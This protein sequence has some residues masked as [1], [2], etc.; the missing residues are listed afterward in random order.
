MFRHLLSFIA[1]VD[2]AHA[3]FNAKAWQSLGHDYTFPE[4]EYAD[5]AA[6]KNVGITFS[7]GGDRAFTTS[8]GQLAAF[9]EL[10]FTED[11][12]YIAGSSGQPPSQCCM[13]NTRDTTSLT[14]TLHVYMTMPLCGVCFLICTYMYLSMNTSRRVVG[15]WGIFL[16]SERYHIRHR[17]AGAH[18]GP[19]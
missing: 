13:H 4:E 7:G 16:L 6:K 19:D 5:V 12:K 8:I 18:R 17:D 15:N 1:C 3:G 2:L 9:H 11:V 10:S 14:P